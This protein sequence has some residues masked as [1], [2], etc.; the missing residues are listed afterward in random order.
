MSGWGKAD[1]KRNYCVFL[2]D[3]E[4][5]AAIVALWMISVTVFAS[6]IPDQLPVCVIWIVTV[7]V[8]VVTRF[9][10]LDQ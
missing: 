6:A 5:E 3:T 10:A 8:S 4:D 1:G 7:S 2:C 9:L